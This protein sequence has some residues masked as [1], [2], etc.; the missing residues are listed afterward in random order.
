MVF[1]RQNFMML[2]TSCTPNLKNISNNN[3]P[4]Q[5]QRALCVPCTSHSL[6]PSRFRLACCY[7]PSLSL[8]LFK[9]PFVYN[10]NS[11]L[12]S[13]FATLLASYSCCGQ[14]QS[15]TPPLQNPLTNCLT[16]KHCKRSM[17]KN[18]TY[19]FCAN[20]THIFFFVTK[21]ALMDKPLLKRC[22]EKR[23]RNWQDNL[24]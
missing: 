1:R 12:I 2:R 24:V 21:L 9:V 14:Q 20:Y 17:S 23:C 7:N 11:E 16:W 22:Q 3:P 19:S 15:S 4:F 6:F 8:S 10:P 5:L 13:K 18:P